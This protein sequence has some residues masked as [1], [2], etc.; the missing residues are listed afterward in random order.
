[1]TVKIREILEILGKEDIARRYF[2]MNSF[3]GALTILG[4]IAALYLSHVTE[5]KII[6]IS[7][8]GAAV[9]MGV[10]GF[11]GAYSAEYAERLNKFKELEK[12]MM[13]DLD[14]TKVEK[15]MKVK[16]VVIAMVDGISPALASIIILVPF[17]L[18]RSG[19][20]SIIDAYHASMILVAGILMGIGAFVG[21]IAKENTV[22]N[23]FKMLSA[24]V[25]VAVLSV[26]LESMKVV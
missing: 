4:I 6:I 22:K 7:C 2:V 1:M 11:W 20:I 19:V 25:I 5:A 13:K 24:G 17:F 14:G 16:T 18:S 21:S 3:D 15:S 23:A 9:A 12:H 8:M 26:A 10:S